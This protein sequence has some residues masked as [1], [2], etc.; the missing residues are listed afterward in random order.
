MH[1]PLRAALATLLCVP[2]AAGATEASLVP[3]DDIV[4]GAGQAEWS[5]R[6]WQWAGSFDRADSPVADTTGERCAS[7]QEG[8]VWF[9]AGTYGTRRTVRSCTVP[10]GKHLFFPLIN[11]VV[12]SMAPGP[13]ECRSLMAAAARMTQDPSHLVLAIDGVREADLALHRQPTPGCFDLLALATP[14]RPPYPAAANGYYV[15]LRPLPPGTHTLEFGGML[16][17]MVQA[18]TYTLVVE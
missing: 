11:Y 9:L 18:V 1:I 2:L 6:W 10:R 8:E 4:A 5:V 13:D 12:A 3:P 16:P 14:K 17:G 7:R 15:M